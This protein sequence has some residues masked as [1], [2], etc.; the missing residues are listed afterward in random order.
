MPHPARYRFAGRSATDP[1]VSATD[2]QLNAP[3]TTSSIPTTPHDAVP[4]FT[5]LHDPRAHAA[6]YRSI[7]NE[8]V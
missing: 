7:E 4:P 5:R 3:W 6:R 8:V 1:L 2:R